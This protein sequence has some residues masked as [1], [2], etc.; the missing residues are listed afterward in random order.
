MDQTGLIHE[1]VDRRSSCIGLDPHIW[2]DD[3]GDDRSG[4]RTGDR[5]R[6]AEPAVGSRQD[7]G[8]E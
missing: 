5:R 6:W 2:Q 7:P 4:L 8:V 3:P 1:G